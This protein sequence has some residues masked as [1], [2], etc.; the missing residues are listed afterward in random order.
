MKCEYCERE[1]IR[2][3]KDHIIA[4]GRGGSRSPK[5]IAMVCALCNTKKGS[6]LPFEFL[7]RVK[8]MGIKKDVYT[9]QELEN[10][11]RN[12]TA[13]LIQRGIPSA[14]DQ[15]GT[16]APMFVSRWVDLT[17]DE[18]VLVGTLKEELTFVNYLPA[19]VGHPVYEFNKDR[20]VIYVKK[21]VPVTHDLYN[22]VSIRYYKSTLAPSIEF[23]LK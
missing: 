21:K 10:I 23:K 9:N 14:K 7:H 8:N 13:I 15:H 11:H 12:L 20:Y 19:P 22:T 3:T 16:G 4:V 2:L 6:L 17:K 18:R 5:N 1:C